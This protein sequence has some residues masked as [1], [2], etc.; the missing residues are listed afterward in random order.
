MRVRHVCVCL[1]C[2]VCVL[3]H[4]RMCEC[5]NW[6]IENKSIHLV[7]SDS[8]V[9]RIS[10][11]FSQIKPSAFVL[12]MWMR[13]VML[14]NRSAGR[15]RM[16]WITQALSVIVAASALSPAAHRY[17]TCLYAINRNGL[18]I[19]IVKWETKCF[20]YTHHTHIYIYRKK[21][22]AR[23]RYSC[24]NTNDAQAN[25]ERKQSTLEI[26]LAYIDG[27]PQVIDSTF[28]RRSLALPLFPNCRVYVISSFRTEVL[29]QLSLLRVYARIVCA[30]A[31]HGLFECNFLLV[32]FWHCRPG[33]HTRIESSTFV[34]LKET[35]PSEHIALLPSALNKRIW[36]RDRTAF[37]FCLHKQS[38]SI[39]LQFNSKYTK[40]PREYRGFHSMEMAS[41]P[42]VFFIFVLLRSG[43]CG[44]DA[45]SWN[46]LV[47]LI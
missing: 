14:S 42:Q 26:L 3:S 39:W 43:N 28:P 8:A 33:K 5:A 10:F 29:L 41:S 16:G 21:H 34:R 27:F 45:D 4:L 44:C 20:N 38:T 30:V 25:R 32:S 15:H 31:S 12:A 24:R 18:K 7:A 17:K 11:H 13:D 37:L 1:V 23:W 22:W 36:F 40:N 6:R 19:Q 47:S 9:T 2:V 46:S 35:L